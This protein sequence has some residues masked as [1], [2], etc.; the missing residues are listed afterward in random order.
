MLKNLNIDN[1]KKKGFVNLRCTWYVGCPLQIQPKSALKSA[2]QEKT[3]KVGE[4]KEKEKKSFDYLYATEWTKLFPKQSLPEKVAA[5]CC[6]T[7]AVSR[8][9]IRAR[10]KSDYI[11]YRDWLMDTPLDEDTAIAI[12]E[13]SWHSMS[14]CSLLTPEAS[15]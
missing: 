9:R 12:M 4:E 10:P 8:E 15:R 13:Y 11:R 6:S 14:P 1:V 2:T 5:S 7:F 3:K